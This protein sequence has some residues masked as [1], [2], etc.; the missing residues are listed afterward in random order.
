METFLFF[1]AIFTLLGFVACELSDPLTPISSP[2]AGPPS[3]PSFQEAGPPRRIRR[4]LA[5][6]RSQSPSRSPSPPFPVF[7]SSSAAPFA[8][9]TPVLAAWR[10]N[11]DRKPLFLD[12]AEEV[13]HGRMYRDLDPVLGWRWRA[14]PKG[15]YEARSQQLREDRA[16]KTPA[17]QVELEI[18]SPANVSAPP[19]PT[20]RAPIQDTPVL[21]ASDLLASIPTLP[22]GIPWALAPQ[23]FLP[24]QTVVELQ[25]AS[26]VRK[27]TFSEQFAGLCAA[28]QHTPLPWPTLTFAEQFALSCQK[29]RH[30]PLPFPLPSLPAPPPPR[31]M[32]PVLAPSPAPAPAPAPSSAPPTFDFGFSASAGPMS[33]SR[34]SARPAGWV[35]PGGQRPRPQ[36]N[37]SGPTAQMLAQWKDY[38]R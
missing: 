23:P 2:A 25:A 31:P 14:Y 4:A 32:V 20:I 1:L 38:V 33:T 6:S 13:K 9:S 16:S 34:T 30:L 19:P 18:Q 5:R 36:E 28:I 3:P 21:S 8:T 37:A 35:R 26:A 15:T 10:R 7:L 27:I 29:T 24:Q 22:P 11:P 17:G 12:E